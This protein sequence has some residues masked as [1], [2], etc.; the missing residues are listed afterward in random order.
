MGQ[1]VSANT[2]KGFTIIEFLVSLVILTLTGVALL[3]TVVLFIHNQLQKTIIAHTIDAA[4]QLQIYSEK[5]GNC[6]D[7]NACDAFKDSECASS[8][9]CNESYC[10]ASDKCVV[11][12]TNPD[13]GRK[14]FYSFN[15]SQIEDGNYFVTLCWEYAGKK[16]FYNAVISLPK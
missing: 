11:C 15:A 12:Y 14:I 13:N 7:K 6:Q 1:A 16:G 2:K 8:V 5:L 3:N 9:S 4:M 10:S